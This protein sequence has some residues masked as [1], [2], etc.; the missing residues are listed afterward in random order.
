MRPSG[1][2]IGAYE[3]VGALGAGG[4]GEVY[5]ARDTRLNR[6]VALKVLPDSVAGDNDRLRRLRREAQLLASL[7]HPNIAHVYGFEESSGDPVLVMEL[8]EGTTLAERLAVVGSLPLEEALSIARQIAAG[9][10]AAHEAGII[11]RDLKPANIKVRDDGAVKILDFGLAKTLEAE[12]VATPGAAALATMTSPAM[13]HAGLILGTA[14]YM[15]PEQAKGKPVDKRVDVWAFGCVVWE[16]LTGRALFAR[17]TVVETLSAIVHHTAPPIDALPVA[18][19]MHVRALL[20]RCLERDPL[21][22]LRDIG[23]ARV[24]LS[25]PS[26]PVTATGT[27]VV[28]R[29]RA[30]ATGGA[31]VGTALAAAALTWQLMP[32]SERPV[33]RL[34]L[35]ASPASGTRIALTRDGN[36]IAYVSE[37]RMFVR[38]LDKL[39]AQDVGPVPPGTNHLFWSYDGRSIGFVANAAIQTMPADGGPVLAICRVPATGQ[40]LDISA[41]EDGTIAFAVWRENLYKVST[42]GGMPTVL[43]ATDPSVD[44]DFHAFAPLSGGRFLVVAHQRQDDGTT[45]DLVDGNHRE[46]LTRD[47]A[48]TAIAAAGDTLLFLRSGVNAGLWAVPFTG[49]PPDMNLATLLAA[50]ATAFHAAS[51]GSVLFAVPAKQAYT[52]SW[53]DAAGTLKPLAGAPVEDLR[54]AELSPDGTHIAYL[55]GGTGLLG[56]GNVFVRDVA[57][58]VDTPLTS[59]RDEAGRMAPSVSSHISWTPGGDSVIYAVGTADDM[60]L[61]MKGVNASGDARQLGRGE[62]GRLSGDGRT[63]IFVSDD[64]GRGTLQRAPLMPDGRLGAAEPVFRGADVPDVND[65]MLSPDEHLL[66][67]SARQSDGSIATFLADYPAVTARILVTSRGRAIQ[68]VPD[69]RGILYAEGRSDERGRPLGRLMSAP[70]TPGPPLK[71]GAATVVIDDGGE[72]RINLTTTRMA[73]D[74][75]LLLTTAVKAEPGVRMVLLQN[76]PAIVKQR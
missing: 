5:R 11:H 24:L 29:W 60:R 38:A 61:R 70:I 66:L 39:E 72:P 4:M 12:T 7:S 35:S 16:M 47:Q 45:L 27:T 59:I 21:L 31:L 2:R 42:S 55:A 32:G 17:E 73:A 51:D 13:T 8:A 65:F 52:F 63:A 71:I 10:E 75:R 43:L 64:H 19:P 28:S 41:L 50:G 3:V 20:A 56:G 25:E 67:Y 9:L 23:E 54:T 34:E 74:G 46:H 58:G 49:K 40:I 18:V 1:T 14:A 69:G 15:A 36:R 22:R 30:L 44:V 33:R 37:G 48:L 53:R 62:N 76:W 26:A 57:S 68:F 6:D